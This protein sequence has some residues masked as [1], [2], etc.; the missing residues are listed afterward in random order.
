MAI[1]KKG[2]RKAFRVML[3]TSNSIQIDPEEVNK[4][5]M[6]IQR[7]SGVQL[8]Q[9]FIANTNTISNIVEDV[10]RKK[11]FFE[12][13]KYDEEKRAEGMKPLRNIFEDVSI[14]AL[15]ANHAPQVGGSVE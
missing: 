8:K 12:D 7:G 2:I 1:E 13:T 5:V 6:A 3:T 11:A 15:Q 10:E 14:P 9:G 4:I